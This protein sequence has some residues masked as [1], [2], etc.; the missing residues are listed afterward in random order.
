MCLQ[1]LLYLSLETR[2]L[3][4]SGQVIIQIT[5]LSSGSV[6]VNF[7]FIF[8]PGLNISSVS[9]ALMGSLQNSSIYVVDSNS[10]YIAG[11]G[12]SFRPYFEIMN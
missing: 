8:Q 6:I 12:Y 1:I 4:T 9:S 10:I 7:S 3:V 5:S 2:A 11:T